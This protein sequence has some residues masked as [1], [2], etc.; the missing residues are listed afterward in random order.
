MLH[1]GDCCFRFGEQIE[2]F[3]AKLQDYKFEDKIVL[4]LHHAITYLQ[5]SIRHVLHVD[6]LSHKSPHKPLVQGNKLTEN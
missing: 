5:G 1:P 6:L 4:N 2:I 3:F